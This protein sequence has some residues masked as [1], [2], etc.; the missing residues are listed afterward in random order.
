MEELDT[1][2]IKSIL[3]AQGVLGE[4]KEVLSITNNSMVIGINHIELD[5]V[6]SLEQIKKPFKDWL[7]IGIL[8]FNVI[9][10][11]IA[12]LILNFD[13]LYVFST[14][15]LVT[16]ITLIFIKHLKTEPYMFF[17]LRTLQKEYKFGVVNSEDA[18]TLVNSL[19]DI[20]ACNIVLND[21]LNQE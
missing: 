20:E 12:S 11:T 13:I 19:E 2:N 6:R 1:S 15:I 8:L 21:D 9:F 10:S 5:D 18:S 3:L 17:K 4:R 16:F 7:S 14:I